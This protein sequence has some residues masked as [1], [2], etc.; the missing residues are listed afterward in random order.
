LAALVDDRVDGNTMV[1]E[2]L[3]RKPAA[4][5]LLAACRHRGTRPERTVVF[6]T[7]P[8]GIDAGRAAGFEFVVGVGRAD[9]AGALRA[10]GADLV[11]ADLGD[12]IEPRL[13][14]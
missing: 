11:V 13:A 14:A 4:D 8:D 5:T 2:R 12:I 1:A 7:T 3:A 9:A 10:H 6:E